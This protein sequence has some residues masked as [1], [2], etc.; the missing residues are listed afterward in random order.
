[1]HIRYNNRCFLS[2]LLLVGTLL[3]S[4][5]KEMDVEVVG[6]HV[7]IFGGSVI[8]QGSGDG[9]AGIGGDSNTGAGSLTGYGGIV[10]ATGGSGGAGIGGGAEGKG[11]VTT[12]SGGKVYV[13]CSAGNDAAC[14]GGGCEADCGEVNITGGHCRWCLYHR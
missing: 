1:M 4:C 5:S 9:T 8:S 2:A 14:I 6:K 12:I 3:L 10:E 11:G 7:F 13:T